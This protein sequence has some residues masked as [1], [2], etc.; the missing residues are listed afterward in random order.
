MTTNTGEATDGKLAK[1]IHEHI[2]CLRTKLAST[3]AAICD[4]KA[5][6][7]VEQARACFLDWEIE[8]LKL[9]LRLAGI[10]DH[11]RTTT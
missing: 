1:R 5:T 7:D 3:N 9:T 8:Q 2:D 6:I 11:K 10:S 4:A